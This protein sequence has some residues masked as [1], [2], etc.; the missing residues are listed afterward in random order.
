MKKEYIYSQLSNYFDSYQISELIIKQTGLSKS[1]LFL[2]TS[3]PHTDEEWLETLIELGKNKYPFEYI[4]KKAEFYGL[5]LFVDE[6]VLIPRND[7][8]IMIDSA[9]HAINKDSYKK[10][11][12]DIGTG[13]S[14]IPI[15]VLKNSNM[16]FIQN[17]YVVDISPDALDVSLKNITSHGLNNQITQLEGSLFEPV[18]NR[19]SSH[20]PL[21]ITANLPYIKNNDHDNMD[22]ET[23]QFEPDLALYGGEQTGFELY[24][25]LIDQLIQEK[26][27]IN[28]PS[29]TLFIEIGFDQEKYSQKYLE[30]LGFTYVL[31]KD[32]AGI[33]RCIEINI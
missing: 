20:I 17:S 31:H 11:Y 4:I 13:S 14:C 7:T 29:I 24:E 6:G 12:I 23:V 21:V 16:N 8:E 1:Q 19:I 10:T 5:E 22:N 32:N 25:E 33:I 9:I 3:L 26:S 18:R 2:C 27:E 15:A 30:N 28:I